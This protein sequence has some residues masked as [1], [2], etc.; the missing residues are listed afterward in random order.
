LL[1]GL[2]AIAVLVAA[3]QWIRLPALALALTR[4]TLALV[5]RKLLHS[6]AHGLDAS[7]CFFKIARVSARALSRLAG[8][9]HGCLG[10]L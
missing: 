8:L 9:L 5:L 3:L 1:A 2:L 4:P 7:Q 6:I 10:L